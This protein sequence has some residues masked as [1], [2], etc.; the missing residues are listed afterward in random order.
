MAF[1]PCMRARW[2]RWRRHGNAPTLISSSR[3]TRWC[4]DCRTDQLETFCFCRCSAELRDSEQN[5]ITLSHWS[6]RPDSFH[7]TA[8]VAVSF[9]LFLSGK[10][11]YFD[12]LRQWDVARVGLEEKKK[13]ESSLTVHAL[14]TADV[15][16]L[17]GAVS[18]NSKACSSPLHLLSVTCSQLFLFG[19]SIE[20]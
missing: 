9:F 10:C 19:M 5:F 6:Q 15:N 17:W 4:I 3:C 14:M 13:K 20:G 16:M 11:F 8:T 1:H 7:F 12:S 2:Q 18:A